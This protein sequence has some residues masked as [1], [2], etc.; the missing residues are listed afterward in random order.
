MSASS[1]LLIADTLPNIAEIKRLTLQMTLSGMSSATTPTLLDCNALISRFTAEEGLPAVAAATGILT[2]AQEALSR[3][4]MGL[5]TTLARIAMAL[6]L[7][8][9]LAKH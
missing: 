2:I 6:T 8:A 9:G 1:T 5:G 7:L 4:E 3:A